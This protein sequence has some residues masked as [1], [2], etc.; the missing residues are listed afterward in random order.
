MPL[1]VICRTVPDARDLSHLCASG[2]RVLDTRLFDMFPRT[3]FFESVT[4]LT[5]A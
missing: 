3:P 1:T 5:L 4:R 2:Y